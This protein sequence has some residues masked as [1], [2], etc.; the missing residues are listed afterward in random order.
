M[1]LPLVRASF[2][3]CLAFPRPGRNLHGVAQGRN[4]RCA[5]A[6]PLDC[7]VR[8]HFIDAP[9]TDPG[10]VE[11]LGPG[12]VLATKCHDG[13]CEVSYPLGRGRPWLFNSLEL[14]SPGSFL[15]FTEAT[16]PLLRQQQLS[17]LAEAI[18]RPLVIMPSTPGNWISIVTSAR[19]SWCGM[20]TVVG[21]AM[22]RGCFEGPAVCQ[23]LARPILWRSTARSIGRLSSLRSGGCLPRRE[24]SVQGH[25]HGGFAAQEIA[26]AQLNFGFSLTLAGEPNAFG[27]KS[28]G[29]V[30]AVDRDPP[31]EFLVEDG[32]HVARTPWYDGGYIEFCSQAARRAA[33]STRTSCRIRIGQRQ[34]R[35]RRSLL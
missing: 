26:P 20:L 28:N 4:K 17:N 18:L 6:R 3:S 33:A 15:R 35:A 22:S 11:P 31:L 5:S 27:A 30:H 2:L 34:I 29:A 32:D 16:A 10:P 19:P 24:G 1:P 14:I 7:L 23:A 9:N 8:H 25:H 12:H 13:K 21:A